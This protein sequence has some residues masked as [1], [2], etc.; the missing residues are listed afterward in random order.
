M[1]HE[2]LN[3]NSFTIN[4]CYEKNAVVELEG[5]LYC[6]VDASNWCSSS[7]LFVMI[8]YDCFIFLLC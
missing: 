8:L 4:L 3:E 5:C 1:R 2:A 7:A 6:L